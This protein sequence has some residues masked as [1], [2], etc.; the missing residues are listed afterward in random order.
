MSKPV[1]VA[2]VSGLTK[3]SISESKEKGSRT[4][5]LEYD[6]GTDLAAASE[7]Y[8]D[9]V[10]YGFYLKG[11]KV[12]LQAVIR[13]QMKEGK[14]DDEIFAAIENWNPSV[15]ATRAKGSSASKLQDVFAK[16]SPEAQAELLAKLQASLQ[17]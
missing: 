10:V 2:E 14:T 9:A 1:E 15:K 5:A 13:R 6:F 17:K 4:L 16:M 11:I 8:S 12:G 3:L 7:L